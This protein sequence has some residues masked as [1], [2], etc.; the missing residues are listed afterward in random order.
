MQVVVAIWNVSPRRPSQEPNDQVWTRKSTDIT[1]HR[2]EI[3][4]WVAYSE[5]VVVN[6]GARL[7]H[8]EVEELGQDEAD[9]AEHADAAVL[10]LRLL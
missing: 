9:N 10:D 5:S 8:G 7:V 2:K 1:K 3:R 6:S 4:R